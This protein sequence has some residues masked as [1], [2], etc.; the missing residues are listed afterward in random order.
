[1]ACQMD[2]FLAPSVTAMH[3]YVHNP[4]AS[5]SPTDLRATWDKLQPFMT[6]LWAS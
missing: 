3:N 5:P 4:H 1:M 2:S 6:A